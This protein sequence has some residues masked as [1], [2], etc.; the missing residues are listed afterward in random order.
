[1][2]Y[3]IVQPDGE[4]RFVRSVVE[5][6][7]DDQGGPVRLAGATQ[8]VTELVQAREL[9]RQSEARLKNAERLAHLGHWDWDVKAN[10]LIWS[11]EC[12][13]IFGGPPNHA[14][15]REDILKA[16]VPEDRERVERE[17]IAS[18]RRKAALSSFGSSGP[19]ATNGQSGPFRR[20]CWTRKA[21]RI[22]S[23][24]LARTSPKLGAS[25]S[26][27]LPGRNWRAWEYWPV[28]SHT[29]SITFWVV[30]WLKQN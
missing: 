26:E 30:C 29:I 18:R 4:V 1:M 14:P 19:T 8:D 6:I 20:W 15:S 22:I 23:L 3:R 17:I 24:V 9:L 11:D 21:S 27:S 5:V 13:R 2:E 16:F 10:Q 7:R 28:V 12:F 25:N